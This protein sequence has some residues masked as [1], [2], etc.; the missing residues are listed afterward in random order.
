[1]L[2]IRD[3][4]ANQVLLNCQDK[5]EKDQKRDR[6]IRLKFTALLIRN[7]TKKNSRQLGFIICLLKKCSN[8]DAIVRSLRTVFYYLCSHP[9]S[10]KANKAVWKVCLSSNHTFNFSTTLRDPGD[11]SPEYAHS[12]MIFIV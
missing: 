4:R 7:K 11:F 6:T 9:Y 5:G 8:S 3:N 1:L 2:K 10:C 12:E